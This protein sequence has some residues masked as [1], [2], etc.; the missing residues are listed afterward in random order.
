MLVNVSKL[1]VSWVCVVYEL[2]IAWII[3]AMTILI[4]KW[5]VP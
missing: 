1:A 3:L 4:Y 5:L 2:Y